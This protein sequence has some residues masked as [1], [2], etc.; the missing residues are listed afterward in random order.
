MPHQEWK[1]FQVVKCLFQ[2]DRVGLAG[3]FPQLPPQQSA[4][5]QAERVLVQ[6]HSTRQS[7]GVAALGL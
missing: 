6:G 1:R 4:A 7:A 2:H 5:A 3:E